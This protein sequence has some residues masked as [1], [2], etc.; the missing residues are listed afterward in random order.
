MPVC[1]SL[2]KNSV[3]DQK[4]IYIRKVTSF[5]LCSSRVLLAQRLY[6]LSAS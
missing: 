4:Y 6:Q 3:S 5:R 2:L 1:S